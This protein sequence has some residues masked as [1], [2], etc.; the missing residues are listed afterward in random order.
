MDALIGEAIAAIDIWLDTTRGPDG[1]GG[2]VVHW[3]CDS[4]AFTGAGL[5]WRYEGIISGYLN[6]YRQTGHD[7]WL[8]KARRAGDDLVR[9]QMPDGRY[10]HS[11]FEVNP[12]SGGTPHEAAC[13]LALLRLAL[14]LR[15]PGDDSWQPYATAAKR[16]L[17]AFII[18]TLWDSATGRLRN[19]AYDDSFVP[20]KA[21]TTAEALLAWSELSGDDKWVRAIVLP[22][23]GDIIAAQEVDASGPTHGAIAQSVGARGKN[24]R[25]FPLYVARCIPALVAGHQ[26][27]GEA[28]YLAAAR[29]AAV[30][31]ARAQLPDGSFPQVIYGDGRINRYPQWIAGAGDIL[32]AMELINGHGL[33]LDTRPALRWLLQG[34][35]S[36]LSLRAARGFGSLVSQREPSPLPDFRDLL[37]VAGWV[38]KAFRYLT[39]RPEAA[40]ALPAPPASSPPVTLP[41]RYDGR[42]AI[43]REDGASVTVRRGQTTL[44]RWRKGADW[45]EMEEF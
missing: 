15:R 12:Q 42:P 21:A 37:G 13:D 2:P 38:D 23:L 7:A 39:G 18:G 25:Y 30:F 19:T 40:A 24:R 10:R 20:N 32:R 45:A 22:I 14:A 16:N 44:Y 5:D 17:E 11:G 28:R 27:T 29:K 36:S 9:G 3:W 33:S 26:W 34:R 43:F 8:V 6:L 31:L 35:A 41:C 1:Y 4:I